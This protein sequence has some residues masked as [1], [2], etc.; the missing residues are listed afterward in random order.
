MGSSLRV[1]QKPEA[2]LEHFREAR[3]FYAAIAATDADNNGWQRDLAVADEHIGDALDDL[4]RFEEALA[5]YQESFRLSKVLAARGPNIFIWQRDLVLIINRLADT[6]LSLSRPEEALKYYD[7]PAQFPADDVTR[8]WNRG[9]AALYGG[10]A[11]AAADDFAALVKLRPAN[12]YNILWLRIARQ[13]AGQ[14]DRDEWATNAAKAD[15]DRW[16]W[17]IVAVYSGSE[18]AEAVMTAAKAGPADGLQYRVCDVDFYAGVDKFA[19]G[20]QA[21]ARTLLEAAAKDCQP[22]D[23]RYPAALLELKRLDNLRTLQAK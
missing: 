1:Q 17:P 2:A 10:S 8:F 4:N 12:T 18:S 6:L 15:R 19:K 14:D 5:A 13:R 22:G 3:S 20:E 11:A 21:E 23:F 16:P 9:R 7:E